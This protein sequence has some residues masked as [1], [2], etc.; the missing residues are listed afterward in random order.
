[1]TRATPIAIALLL[2]AVAGAALPACGPSVAAKTPEPIKEEK[3]KA[4]G[5]SQPA[6]K[7]D[8]T[9]QAAHALAWRANIP[10]QITVILKD[11]LTPSSAPTFTYEP[12]PPDIS[13]E[14][15]AGAGTPSFEI[16]AVELTWIYQPVGEDEV[17][18]GPTK[19]PI[20]PVKVFGAASDQPGLPF[21]VRIPLDI[22]TMKDP[23]T[24]LEPGK[25]VSSASVMVTFFDAQG[26]SVFGNQTAIPL[27][28][29]VRVT[30]K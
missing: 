30:L 26:K 10:S 23:F 11:G 13:I 16:S 12:S 27:R 9:G 24:T 18:I 7:A 29:P 15:Q 8:P 2:A 14:L 19:L 22:Q 25:R 5:Q 3:R 20:V 6:E 1:M 28:I 4:V 21:R 17:K